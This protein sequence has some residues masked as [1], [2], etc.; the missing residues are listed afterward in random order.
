VKEKK[1]FV[2]REKSREKKLRKNSKK[3]KRE[4][5]MY[6]GEEKKKKERKGVMKLPNTL[7][8]CIQ[9]VLQYF[10]FYNIVMY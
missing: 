10:L 9:N 1:N 3:K 4:N 7:N 8:Y 5:Q 2:W 6:E